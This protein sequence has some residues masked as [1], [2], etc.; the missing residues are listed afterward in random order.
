[1]ITV[2]SVYSLKGLDLVTTQSTHNLTANLKV[3]LKTF[4]SRVQKHLI[5]QAAC[6]FELHCLSSYKK[7]SLVNHQ[8]NQGGFVPAR[9]IFLPSASCVFG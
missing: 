1:M 4:C 9:P 6:W 2:Q 7:I 8:Q 5:T 3:K